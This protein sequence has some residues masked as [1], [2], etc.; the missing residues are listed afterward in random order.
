MY[1]ALATANAFARAGWSVTVLTPVRA[2]FETLTDIDP[3]TEELIEPGIDVR[4][5]DFDLSRGETDLA[6]WPKWRAMAPLLWSGVKLLNERT[7]FPEPRYGGWKRHLVAAALAV[8]AQN[9]VDL[10]IGTANPNVDFSP[11]W[12]LNRRHG[13]PFVMDYRDTWHLDMYSGRRTAPRWARSSRVERRMQARAAEVWFV[14]EPI[15]AWHVSEHPAIAD[16]S[17][18]VSNGFDADFLDGFTPRT[19]RSG[20]AISIGYLGTVYGPMPLEQTFDG[21]VLARERSPLLATAT[22]DL[23]GRLGHYAIPDARAQQIIDRYTDHGVRYHGKVSKTEVSRVYSSFDGLALILGRSRYITSG[24]VFEYVATGLPIAAFHHPDTASTSVLAAYP[25]FVPAA[26]DTAE[27]FA[28]AFVALAEL[29]DAS[30]PDDSARARE[31]ASVWERNR[32][33]DPRIAALGALVD[34]SNRG[35]P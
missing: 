2:V 1:R 33:L 24:K 8:Q 22:L 19:R 35:T 31:A 9:P 34:A 12:A 15:R 5:V 13:V 29:I 25:R 17:H 3:L 16:T 27:A 32:Q 28:D 18:V 7:Q 20:D 23:H 30:G 6:R 21:W 4:R 14:N 11:G 10:V 26:D